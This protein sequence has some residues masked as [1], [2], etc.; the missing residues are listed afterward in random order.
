MQVWPLKSL[1]PKTY[2]KVKENCTKL[3]PTGEQAPLIPQINVENILKEKSKLGNG[4][5]K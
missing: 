3:L 4:N 2:I 5:K 1:D